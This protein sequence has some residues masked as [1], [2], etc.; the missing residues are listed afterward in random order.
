MD[1]IVKEASGRVGDI[2]EELGCLLIWRIMILIC[3]IA[4]KTVGFELRGEHSITLKCKSFFLKNNSG[5]SSN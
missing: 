2:L 1:K 3:K 4:L 5:R